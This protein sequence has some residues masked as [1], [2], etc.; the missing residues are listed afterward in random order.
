MN[1]NAVAIDIQAAMPRDG[2]AVAMQLTPDTK[3]LKATYN[4]S[5]SSTAAVTLQTANTTTGTSATSLIEVSA[6][7]GGVFLKWTSAASA[8]T[9]GFDEYVQA[10]TTRHYAV[11]AGI[12]IAQFISATGTLVLIEK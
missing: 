12:L 9:D 3:A 10:G 2:N 5:I 4:A 7:T 8:A 11:P 6:I 1:P